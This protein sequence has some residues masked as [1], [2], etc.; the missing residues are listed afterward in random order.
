MNLY[1]NTMIVYIK[2]KNLEEANDKLVDL[3][4]NMLDLLIPEGC[5]IRLSFEIEDTGENADVE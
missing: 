1:K 3:K 2:A 5:S 4:I